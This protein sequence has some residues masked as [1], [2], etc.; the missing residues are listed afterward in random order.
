MYVELT[1]ASGKSLR[2]TQVSLQFDAT[3]WIRKHMYVELSL[4]PLLRSNTSQLKANYL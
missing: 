1:L 3:E 4:D 2:T